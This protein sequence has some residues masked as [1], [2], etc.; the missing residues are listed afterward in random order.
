[1]DS[2]CRKKV[3]AKAKS[4]KKIIPAEKRTF[5]YLPKLNDLENSVNE[6]IIGQEAVVKSLCTKVYEGICF[7]QLKGNILLIGKSGT[8][9]TEMIRQIANTLNLPLTIEDA[10]RY[11]QEG[12]VGESV[13]DMIYN[14]ISEANNNLMLAQRGIIFIDEIDKKASKRHESYSD[15]S[16][17]EVLKSLLK[18]VEGT[19]IYVENPKFLVNPDNE[20]PE[21]AFDTS[22]IIFIFGGSFEGIDKVRD[23]RLKKE[24]HIGFA[25]AETN[26]IAIKSYMNTSFTKED[27]I[28]YGIPTELVGR[29]ANIYETKELTVEELTK[30][31]KFSKKSIFKQYENLFKDLKIELKYTDELLY[32]I[33]KNAKT[34]PTGARELNS[35]V[36]YIFE[37][38]MY[39]IFTSQ[40]KIY[41][42]C[43]LDDD[44]I[45]NNEHY[46]WEE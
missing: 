45:F 41:K 7:P 8:G 14:I 33:A 15:I 10:T 22:N 25:S 38:I 23:K 20:P 19:K 28:E 40:S 37:K 3:K 36:S 43:I 11:T 16:K 4:K 2:K 35:Q 12:Y 29:I 21:L 27:L 42:C 1:M 17:G 9:K 26:H 5:I 44:I 30:I 18:V 39:D 6:T 46:R 34:Y 13:T 31:L 32:N 24:N